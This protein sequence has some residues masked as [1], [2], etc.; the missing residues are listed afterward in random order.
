MGFRIWKW[1]LSILLALCLLTPMGT[2]AAYHHE[3]EQDAGVFLTVYPDKAGTKLDSCNLCHS[4]GHYVD[5]KGKTVNLGSCQWCHYTYG[6]DKS[7]DISKTLNAY[8]VDYLS[9]GRN[10]EALEA[11]KSLDSD[12][13]TYANQVEIAAIR[14]PGDANDDPSKVIAPSRVFSLADLEK[15][16]QVNQFLLMNASKSTDFYAKYT[17]VSMEYLLKKTLR[18]LPSATGI[19]VFAPDGFSQYHPLDYDPDALLYQVYGTYPAASYYYDEEA[20]IAKNTAGW[21]DYNASSCAGRSD[22]DIIK[23][24]KPLRMMLAYKR[25]GNS[26]T[27]GTLTSANKL[28]G[29]GPFRVVPPQ[30]APGPPDQR[31]TATNQSVDWPY[32][33]SADHNAGFST[34][35]A[36]I[37]KVEP[38]PSGTTDIDSLEAGW[39]FV[40]EGKIIF[41]GAIDPSATIK[42]KLDQLMATIESL[43]TSLFKSRL[44][45][46]Q[47]RVNI[48]NAKW[49]FTSGHR[50]YA[51]KALKN[52]AAPRVDGCKQKGKPDAND[53]IK[54][55]NTQNQ[56][57][58]AVSEILVLLDIL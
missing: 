8:G 17:G 40:D 55:C 33:A 4:G 13:D 39:D 15:L 51:A 46:S 41:Y 11:I 34:R 50:D 52:D 36:T 38:L 16:P 45:K 5:Q 32:N 22:G 2:F 10:A 20:N 1:G 27:T 44:L 57:Y 14:F 26:L 48:R 28:D 37:V 29:E 9:H 24:P 56:I 53:W 54:D 58:W 23:N 6:Y 47:L 7:G 3:G 30:K 25:D 35:T 42:E 18:V 19:K 31:S 12:N 43:D 21:V 49:F